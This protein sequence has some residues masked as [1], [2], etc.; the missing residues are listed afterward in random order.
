MSAQN[1]RALPMFGVLL[2]VRGTAPWTSGPRSTRDTSRTMSEKSTTRDLVALVRAAWDASNRD[3]LDALLSL[4]KPDV[5]WDASN[6]GIG[7]FEGR[8]A[9]RSLLE[10]WFGNYAE[11]QA[12]VEEI[13]DLGNGGAFAV[14]RQSGRIANSSG[15]VEMREA[16]VYE[17]V[18]NLVARITNYSDI[19]EARAVAERLAE[20]RR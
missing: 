9:I 19:D 14:T 4:Y 10:D 5:V 8:A 12:T 16:F 13:L 7:T 17:F 20:E 6:R 18:D 11:W 1:A 15:V 2:V 3:D